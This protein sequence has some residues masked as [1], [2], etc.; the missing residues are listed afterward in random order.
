M[1]SS[2]QRE[3]QGF[4]SREVYYCQGALVGELLKKE[5]I[6][7]DDFVNLYDEETDEY[8][9][10][11]EYWIV[12]EWLAEKLEQEGEPIIKSDFGIW[13]GRTCTGQSIILDSVIEK[14]Y[15]DLQRL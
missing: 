7:Y 8:Q 5:I 12:S 11:Y 15:T 6:S 1:D 14:I 10:I 13:W 4:V 3:L 2:L 9:E